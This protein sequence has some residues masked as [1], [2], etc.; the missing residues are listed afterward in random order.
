MRL[1]KL[2]PMVT[3][4][5]AWPLA[6]QVL[7]DDPRLKYLNPLDRMTP[8]QQQAFLKRV[9]FD[10]EP[11]LG[12]KEYQRIPRTLNLFF[13]DREYSR[14]K[15]NPV[16]GYYV[17]ED[18]FRWEDKDVAFDGIASVGL[19]TKLITPKAWEAAA[20]IVCS[21][22]NLNISPTAKVRI[23]GGTVYVNPKPTQARP[24]ADI[25]VEFKVSSPTGVILYRKGGSGA[26]LGDAIGQCL[27]HVVNF[28]HLLGSP[29]RP[30]PGANNPFP[31]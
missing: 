29:Q 27:D 14:L 26:T 3:L 25:I 16:I 23:S 1:Q 6:A 30:T 18:G 13:K 9:F 22:R 17:A 2:C 4:F 8:Q 20:N 10:K 12:S 31:K 21:R 7:K 24:V 5:L 28:S 19:G 11:F 15:G